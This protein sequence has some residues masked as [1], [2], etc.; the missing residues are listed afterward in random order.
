MSHPSVTRWLQELR[1]GDEFAAERLWEF[2]QHRLLRLA[3]H[4][5]KRGNPTVYDEED[6]ALSA[7]AAL[8][9]SVQQGSYSDIDNRDE[10][11]KLLAVITLNKARNRA[12]DENRQRRGGGLQVSDDLLEEVAS[13]NADPAAT[14]L[15]KDECQRLLNQLPRREIQ[16]VALLKVEGYT[17]E[18]IAQ[19]LG[20]TT[21]SVYRRL[22]FIR[23]AWSKEVT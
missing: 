17:N 21:R 4:E 2:V 6:V 20:C 13:S 18:Q 22:N 3:H 23:D 16:L 10:L 8:C 19:R 15:M 11:W 5:V 1:R 9:G 14:M 7:F 12:R